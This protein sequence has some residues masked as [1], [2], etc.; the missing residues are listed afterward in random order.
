MLVTIKTNEFNHSWQHIESSMIFYLESSSEVLMTVI[1]NILKLPL[2][3]ELRS[4]I[5]RKLAKCNTGF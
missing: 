2:S 4:F 1:K 5:P 3:E